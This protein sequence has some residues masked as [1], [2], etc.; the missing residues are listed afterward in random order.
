MIT[1]Y[2]YDNL[3]SGAVTLCPS[4]DNTTFSLTFTAASNPFVETGLYASPILQASVL[5]GWAFWDI[6]VKGMGPP[7][8]TI[9]NGELP[10]RVIFGQSVACCC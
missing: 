4:G 6:P 2:I 1:M 5:S 9:P 8:G 10:L 3:L 7:S